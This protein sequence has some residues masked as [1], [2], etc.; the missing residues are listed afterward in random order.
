MAQRPSTI[1]G[2]GGGTASGKTTLA[3]LFTE[4]LGE[5]CLLISHDRYYWDVENPKGYNYDTPLALDNN[6]LAENLQDLAEGKPTHL[7]IYDF[8]SHARKDKTELVYPK[9]IVLVEGIL[10]LAIPE[11]RGALDKTVFVDTPEPLRLER[12]I[13]RDQKK[14]GRSRESVLEQYFET[15]KPMHD[16]HV[17]PSKHGVDLLLQGH[18]P[19]DQTLLQL[20]EFLKHE[21]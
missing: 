20:I 1:V 16:K 10:V 3:R 15:V 9:P 4:R 18:G 2:I 14:R 13:A 5:G 8:A 11:I 17:E 7:P 21:R 12:R 19:I 6:R